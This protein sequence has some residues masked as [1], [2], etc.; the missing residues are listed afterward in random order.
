M[1]ALSRIGA[2]IGMGLKVA[3]GR[4]DY[5]Q[6]FASKDLTDLGY[7]NADGSTYRNTAAWLKTFCTHPRLMSAVNRIGM[8]VG[9]TSWCMLRDDVKTGKPVIIDSP[10]N[11]L[12]SDP[13]KTGGGGSLSTL[14][15]LCTIYYE[16]DGNVFLMPLWNEGPDRAERPILELW[17][18][19]PH[20]VNSVPT[21]DRPW[22][23]V[24]LPYDQAT[25]RIP[26]GEVIWIRRPN[27]CNPFG[28]GVGIANALGDEVSQDEWAAKY[29]SAWF[30]NGARPDLLIASTGVKNVDEADRLREH[31]NTRYKGF[32]NAFKVAFMKYDAKVHLLTTSH[33]DMEWTEGRRLLRDIIFQTFNLPPEVM[34]VVE[35]SNRATAD[36]ALYIYSLQVLLPRI[37]LLCEELNRL[38]VPLYYTRAELKGLVP[39]PYLGFESPVRET[40]EFKL[41]KAVELFKTGAITRDECREQTGYD[42]VGGEVGGEFLQPTNM[43]PVGADGSRPAPAQAPTDA[44]SYVTIWAAR[45]GRIQELKIARAA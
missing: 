18:L 17:P 36:A 31:W 28:R 19:P 12:F 3:F 24:T 45:G 4:G 7:G 29:N 27:P 39:K 43:Q 9:K 37:Q 16:L 10:I 14:L 30:R 1:N 6:Y 35:N 44:R 25:D 13:W 8:D 11:D 5:T 15:W 34:G 40:N 42:P 20:Y 2:G 33:K 38:L 41:Q 32:W 22:F 23:E 26:A 21:P